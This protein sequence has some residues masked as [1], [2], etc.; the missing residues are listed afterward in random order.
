M[1]YVAEPYFEVAEQL[2]TGLTGGVARET[3][4]FFA[5]ANAFRFEH[6]DAVAE[7]TSVIGQANG[8]FRAFAQGIDFAVSEAGELTLLAA[9]DNPLSPAQ[10]AAW[11]D[12]ATEFY[13]SYYR[14]NADPLITDR[15]VGSVTRTLG[16]AFARELTDAA[17]AARAR[18]RLGVCRHGRGQ[19]PRSR[20]CAPCDFPEAPR[21]RERQGALLPRHSGVRRHLHPR[22]HARFDGAQPA[23]FVRDHCA[24]GVAARAARR[25][26]RHPRRS[27]WRRGRR[28]REDHHHHR[29]QHSG[30]QRCRECR[31]DGVRRGGRDRYGTACQGEESHR[32]RGARHAACRDARAHRRCG[33]QGERHQDRR[34]PGGASRVV[35]VFVAR[36][37]R[38]DLAALVEQAILGARA[39]GIRF[40]HNLAVALPFTPE[41]TLPGIDAA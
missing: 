17:Q 14:A 19:R 4:R 38:G 28:C 13:V 8:V 26:G 10:G 37:S 7:T 21:L 11:P 32:T 18:V 34:G 24:K 23:G 40:E 16:E 36:G 6:E 3:H 25:R 35:E 20:R 31:A 9:E 5:A 1:S 33:P 12:E 27:T 29:S 39:A 2:L 22:R 30:D 41:E 15:N